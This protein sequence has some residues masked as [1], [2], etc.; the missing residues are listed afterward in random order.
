MFVCVCVHAH[1]RGC[2]PEFGGMQHLASCEP[3]PDVRRP[4]VGQ[5]P[6]GGGCTGRSHNLIVQPNPEHIT[7]EY[8]HLPQHSHK[9]RGGGSQ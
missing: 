3:Q 9:K 7:L 6:L 1:R 4:D 8:E 2:R 5:A